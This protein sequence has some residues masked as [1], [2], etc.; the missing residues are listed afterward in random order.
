MEIKDGHNT[1]IEDLVLV[2]RHGE[3]ITISEK[4]KK[5]ILSSRKAVEKIVASGKVKYGITTGFGAF[6]NKVIDA[7]Q[8]E[9]LQ[10]S[11]ILSHAVGIGNFFPVMHNIN[12]ICAPFPA[13][14]PYANIYYR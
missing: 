1:T 12:H 4:N 5:K 7:D 10:K 11:L 2:A 13:F 8:T 3:K 6:K 9:K 14:L